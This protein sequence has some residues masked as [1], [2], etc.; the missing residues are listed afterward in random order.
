M[1]VGIIIQ[2]RMGSMRLPGKVLR[3]VGRKPL[4][5]HV[6]DRLHMLRCPAQSIVATSDL[7]R[8]DV[9]VEHC[10]K[11]MTEYFRGSESDVLARYYHCA[12]Q[13]RFDHIVRLTADNPFTDIAELDR[14]ID[15]H[16]SCGFD[17]SHSFER[18]PLG[19]GAE[20]FSFE[21][22]QRSYLEGMKENHREHVNEYIQE[23]KYLFKIGELIVGHE[24]VNPTLRLTVDT[25][26][27]YQRACKIVESD[28]GRWIST[29]E[30]ISLCLRFA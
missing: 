16:L 6:L 29:E 9:I 20:I 8:D 14:L 1:N 3:I 17:Y 28:L 23:N 10:R 27:D 26:E 24:K 21:A 19:V 7:A 11:R 30:A 5:D 18:M 13:K 22:L 4:L 25:M 12:E 2:A 15:L